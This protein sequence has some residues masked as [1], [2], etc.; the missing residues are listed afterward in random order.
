MQRVNYAGGVFVT[1]D[2]VADA[3]LEY[4]A[5]LANADRAATL[6]VPSAGDDGPTTVK[7]LVGPAS[8]IVAEP[9]AGP[10]V[11][12]DVDPFLD[13][14]RGAIRDHRS[15]PLPPDPGSALYWDL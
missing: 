5:V 12:L 2:E 14:V 8:Q 9:V 11:D 4:A 6:D 15:R 1:S 13:E 3:L 7:I 10:D